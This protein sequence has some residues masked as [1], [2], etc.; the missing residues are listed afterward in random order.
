MFINFELSCRRW[1]ARFWINGS[2][3]ALAST[4]HAVRITTT[5]RRKRIFIVFIYERKSIRFKVY[6]L[7]TLHEDG[8]ITES[9]KNIHAVPTIFTHIIYILYNNIVTI[10]LDFSRDRCRTA[11]PVPSVVLSLLKANIST[12]IQPKV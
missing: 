2:R 1:V 6:T 9:I 3:Y 10:I 8:S 4:K 5:I 7:Y 12:R 11:S